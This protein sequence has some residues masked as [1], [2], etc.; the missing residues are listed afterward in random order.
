VIDSYIHQRL[1]YNEKLCVKEVVTNSR[2]I[3]IV[4]QS[5]E[6]KQGKKEGIL[7]FTR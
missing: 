1:T 6:Q 7:T 2:Y 4:I 5:R 3:V